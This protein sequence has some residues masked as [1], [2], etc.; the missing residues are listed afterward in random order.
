MAALLVT[1]AACSEGAAAAAPASDAAATT[2]VVPIATPPTVGPP[3]RIMAV[4]DSITAGPYYRAPLQAL[5]MLDGCRFDFV[6]SQVDGQPDQAG[7]VDPQ[8]EGYGGRTADWL[9]ARAQAWATADDPDV[10][11]VY[12]GVN[13]FY[14][15]NAAG[16]YDGPAEVGADLANL[17]A[18]LQAGAPQAHIYLAGIMPAVAIEQQVFDYNVFAAALGSDKVTYVDLNSG[19]A[20]GNDT[21]DGVH[22]NPAAAQRLAQGW[23]DAL[24]P[25]LRAVCG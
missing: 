13:D 1:S 23:Y 14:Q 2:S 15:P 21:V 19:F 11:L 17:V 4:G 16:G 5:L 3:L 8:H 18:A 22:P 20:E 24:K 10:I 9:A 6:G 7:L 12:A 25:A